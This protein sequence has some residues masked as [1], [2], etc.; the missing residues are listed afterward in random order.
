MVSDLVSDENKTR[1]YRPLQIKNFFRIFLGVSDSNV[2]FLW[3][4]I[5]AR[6]LVT[7]QDELLRARNYYRAPE[8]KLALEKGGHRRSSGIWY[9]I[10]VRLNRRKFLM[11]PS[12]PE[13]SE[14][15]VKTILETAK[16]L[17][18]S[19]STIYRL[20]ASGELEVT[21]VLSSPRITSTEIERYL[22]RQLGRQRLNEVRG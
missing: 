8:P 2:T 11:S 22:R 20:I 15:M 13:Y 9:R 5:N 1:V 6:L 12:C 7:G 16:A 3:C 4:H 19:R 17:R 18:V 10:P 14:P 21:Y